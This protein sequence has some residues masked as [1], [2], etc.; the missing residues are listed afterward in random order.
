MRTTRSLLAAVLVTALAT[1]GVVGVAAPASAADNVI[2]V[3]TISAL[4][5]AL[6]GPADADV[7]VATLTTNILDSGTLLS[8]AVNSKLDLAGHSL[9]L[10]GISLASGVDFTILDSVGGGIYYGGAYRTPAIRSHNATLRITGGTFY[11]SATDNAAAIGGAYLEDAGTIIISG[12]YVDA[13]ASYGAGI[14]NG[15][16]ATGTAGNVTISGGQVYAHSMVSYARSAAIGGGYQATTPAITISGGDVSATVD[17][18]QFNSA[19]GSGQD[20]LSGGTVTITGGNV[21]AYGNHG[22]PGI[23]TAD[24]TATDTVVTISGSSTMVDAYGGLYAAAIGGGSEASASVTINGGTVT[25]TGGSTSGSKSPGI[26]SGSLSETGGSVTITGGS[27]TASAPAVTNSEGAGIG[28]A[29]GAVS[30]TITISGGTVYAS[31]SLGGAGIGTGGGGTGGSITISGGDVTAWSGL[32]AA[33]IGGAQG[34]P[35]G[36]ITISG[37]TVTS[38]GSPQGAGI[39]GGAPYGAGGSVTISG[40]TVTSHKQGSGAAIGGGLYGHGADLLIGAG[41]Y[42]TVVADSGA[43]SSTIVGPGFQ[44]SSPDFHILTVVGT[45]ELGTGSFLEYPSTGWGSATVGAGGIIAGAGS[46]SALGEIVNHGSISAATISGNVSDHNYEVTF[47]PNSP[48]AVPAGTQSVRVYATSFTDGAR[49]MPAVAS[50]DTNWTF[51]GWSTSPTGAVDFTAASTLSSDLTVYAVWAPRFMQISQDA[52]AINAGESV[53]FGMEGIGVDGSGD[54]MSLG[55]VTAITTWTSNSPDAVVSGN[56]ITFNHSGSF[57]V[58][59]TIGSQSSSTSVLVAP[60]PVVTLVVTPTTSTTIVAGELVDFTVEAFDIGGTSKGDYTYLVDTASS[61]AAETANDGEIYFTKAGTRTIT[62][63]VEGDPTIFDTFTVTVAAAPLRTINVTGVPTSVPAGTT[64]TFT[65]TGEDQYGN[66]LGDVSSQLDFTNSGSE[67]FTGNAVTFTEVNNNIVTISHPTD[68]DVMP[69][70]LPIG[71]TVGGL[72]HLEFQTPPTTATAGDTA[73]LVVYGYDAYD[74]LIGNFATAMFSSDL[75]TDPITSNAVRFLEAGTHHVVATV[76]AV[77]VQTDVVVSADVPDHLV[78]AP[79]IAGAVPAGSSRTYSASTADAYGNILADVTADATF[80]AYLIPDPDLVTGSTVLFETLGTHR[81]QAEWNDDSNIRGNLN[82]SVVAGALARIELSPPSATVAYYSSQAFTVAG[83]D[84]YDNPVTV[85]PALV[86]LTSSGAYATTGLSV[87][88]MQLGA[89]TV[90]A[91]VSGL[92]DTSSVTVV[93]GALASIN[94][95]PDVSPVTAGDVVPIHV[96]G[97][98]SYGVDIA[99]SSSLVTFT[100]S[101]PSDSFSSAG[102]GTFTNAGT[103]VVTASYG[104]FTDT[105][106][107]TVNPDVPDHLIVTSSASGSVTAGQSRTFTAVA[108]DAYDNWVADVSADTTFSTSNLADIDADP[109]FTFDEAG[110]R[111]IGATYHFDPSVTGSLSV[112]VVG[113]EADPDSLTIHASSITANQYGSIT[114]TVTGEDEFGNPLAGLEDNVLITS[115]QPTDVISGNTI[116]FPHASPHVIT[117]ALGGA[118]ASLLIQVTPAALNG[119]ALAGTGTESGLTLLAAGIV[120]LFG[121]LVVLLNRRRLFAHPIA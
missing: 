96:D 48:V 3:G 17:S 16:G 62:V 64:V 20:G 30:P 102:E 61:N 28:G 32:Y 53:T 31:G 105:V 112:V 82:V 60:G 21:T 12:G 86:T 6:D 119:A 10:Q 25:A 90:T 97:Y 46:V 80:E 14:G 94:V 54:P 4:I 71:V 74:N 77:T 106:T 121:I 2:P 51:E 73:Y 15:Q 50:S 93:A 44:T 8:V 49:S 72:D 37:G 40:G 45:L 103:R 35:G 78:I 9:S 47:V 18:S 7:P 24:G 67:T 89:H 107:V 70:Q 1:F 29:A 13:S 65:V 59:G 92:T 66:A 87:Q 88:F 69:I 118:S 104:G 58:T 95:Y 109:T 91:H 98:D 76:G 23:G 81:V 100:S 115:D 113:N 56:V 68:I 27:V 99:I 34:R 111:T 63:S 36:S 43:S 42:V 79:N 116:T 84:A 55:D 22:A 75:R 110:T 57:I 38:L 33:G 5:D 117:V 26:G 39:G 52:T 120:L 41:A 108:Y 19:I 85:S 83:F 101:D 114:I 11:T